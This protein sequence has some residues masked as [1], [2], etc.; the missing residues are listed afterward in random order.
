M[1]ARLDSSTFRLPVEKLRAGYYS[2]AYFTSTKALLE[3]EGRHPVVVLQ[4]F[5]KRDAVFGG[6]NEPLAILRLCSGHKGPAGWEPGWGKLEVHALFEGDDIA[7]R[8]PVL[9]VAGDYGLF[10]HL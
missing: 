5:Q 7:P 3:A 4:V 2:D 9:Q 6:I 1:R 10:C 8:E